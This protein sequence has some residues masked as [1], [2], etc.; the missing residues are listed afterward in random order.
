M[1]MPAARRQEWIDALLSGQYP[2]GVRQLNHAGNFCCL[3]VLCE[4]TPLIRKTIEYENDGTPKYGGIQY[5]NESKHLPMTLRMRYSAEYC[6][7]NVPLARVASLQGNDSLEKLVK[8]YSE[9]AD[10]VAMPDSIYG[11]ADY[12]VNVAWLNDAGVSFAQIAEL[13]EEFVEV[14]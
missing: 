8:Q 12:F 7:F 14:E 2:Q 13:I 10:G 3:G 4:I 1:K 5:N 11:K 9:C 6:G